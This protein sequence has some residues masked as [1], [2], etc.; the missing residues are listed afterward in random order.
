MPIYRVDK[1]YDLVNA[2]S[3]MLTTNDLDDPNLGPDDLVFVAEDFTYLIYRDEKIKIDKDM[4]FGNGEI[5]MI[6][7]APTFWGKYK[8]TFII[9]CVV[10]VMAIVILTLSS[11][12]EKW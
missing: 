7:T 1:I 6:E 5:K 12:I 2:R 3:W 9:G 4:I 10:V 8:H 11:Y